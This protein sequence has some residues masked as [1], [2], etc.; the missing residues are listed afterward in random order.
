M[1]DKCPDT[2]DTQRF[3]G[4]SYYSFLQFATNGI[5]AGG[6]Y[7]SAGYDKVQLIAQI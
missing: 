7:V 3:P 4:T 5:V 6:Y 1:A 2:V